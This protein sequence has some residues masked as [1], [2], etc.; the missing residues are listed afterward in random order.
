ML[1][2]RVPL[3]TFPCMHVLTTAPQ[4]F[5][6][7][8]ECLPAEFRAIGLLPVESVTPSI[9]RVL[10][11]RS[12]VT[13][14]DDGVPVGKVTAIDL[15]HNLALEVTILRTQIVAKVRFVNGLGSSV[16]ASDDHPSILELPLIASDCL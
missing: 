3:M 1:A 10:S 14:L 16:I 6:Q 7:V 9:A 5:P 15:E 2:F 13:S 8:H 12:F 4:P 11:E